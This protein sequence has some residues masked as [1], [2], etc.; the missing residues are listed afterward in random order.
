MR[1]D[2]L[3]NKKP[4]LL[5]PAG[6]YEKLVYAV[7]YGADAVYCALDRFG[8][9]ASA[10]NFTAEELVSGVEY[11][12]AHGAKV[13]CTMN[14]MP[15]DGEF[16]HLPDYIRSVSAAGADAFIV[17][18]PG[19]MDA[20]FKY[21]SDPVVHLS[22]QASTVNSASVRFWSRLGVKRVVLA[23]ELSLDEIKTI[24]DNIDPETELECFVHGAMCVSYSGRCLMSNYF[25]GRDANKGR[26]AQPCRWK[27]HLTEDKNGY[28]ADAE[29][30]DGGTYVFSSK[31]MNMIAHVRKLCEAGIDSFKIEGRMKSAYY[32]AALA[33]AYRIAIDDHFAGKPF[34]ERCYSETESVSH[35]E[36]GTGYYF[37]SPGTDANVVHE[38]EYISDRPFLCTVGS[39]D[40]NTGLAKCVQRN[41]MTVGDK[42]NLLS[43]GGFGRDLVVG[44]MFDSE[45]Q[46][47]TSTPHPAMEF[48]LR[49]DG[50]KPMDIIRGGK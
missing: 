21:A 11:A 32:T 7:N 31:D 45:M 13:Y 1:V 46:P 34:D 48:Y 40:V 19:V 30:D 26:C 42:V 8:M 49:I 36:Y 17:S 12:H 37:S 43:P 38:N 23:R 18:D 16:A 20:V 10:G 47:I 2:A 24:R 4:E 39:Y 25:T 22:T 14:T 6:N 3:N 50:A 9:R 27:Y 28:T 29:Q 41:K 35:R 5:C 15:R 44:E 33:N